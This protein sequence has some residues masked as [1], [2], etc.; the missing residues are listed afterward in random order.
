MLVKNNR[1]LLMAF[2]MV[3]LLSPPNHWQLR[4]CCI[5]FNNIFNYVFASSLLTHTKDF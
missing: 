2:H 3:A 5:N 4:P 1:I